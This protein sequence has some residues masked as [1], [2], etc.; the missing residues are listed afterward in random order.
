MPDD[1]FISKFITDLLPLATSSISEGDL[2]RQF[3]GMVKSGFG[4]EEAEISNSLSNVASTGTLDEYVANT[5]KAYIDN[6]L[7]EYSSFPEL[8]DYKGRGFR[9]CAILPI[10]ANGR[11][12]STLRMLSNQES[13]FTENMLKTVD[14]AATFFA[15][16]Y[17]YKSEISKNSRLAEYFDASFNSGVAQMLV[18]KDDSIVK[19]NKTAMLSFGMAESGIKNLRQLLSIGFDDLMKPAAVNGI[20]AYFS[21]SDSNNVYRITPRRV[22]DALLHV[23]MVNVTGKLILDSIM[24]SIAESRDMYVIFARRDFTIITS[25]KNFES[26]LRYPSSM[27]SGKQ[28]TELLKENDA[29]ALLDA[30]KASPGKP[31]SLQFNIMAADFPVSIR[32]AVKAE[33]FGYVIILVNTQAEKSAEEAK[34]NINEFVDATSDVVITVDNL[35]YI[36]DCNLPVDR[37][38]GYGREELVGRAIKDLYDDSSILDRDMTY[39]REKGKVDN[40]YV[41]LVKKDMTKEAAVQSMRLIRGIG[42]EDR[43]LL[44]IKELET[45]RRMDD[46]EMAIRRNNNEMVKLKS[47][48]DLKSQFIYNISHELK[49]PLTNIK[50]FSTLLGEGQ[51]GELNAEQK[52][53]VSTIVSESDRLLQII[54]QVLDAAKLEPDQVKMDFKEVDMHALRDNPSIRALEDAAR[55]KGLEFEWNVYGSVPQIDADPSRLIQVFVNLVGNSIK[56]TE[57]G[58]IKVNIKPKGRT[59]IECEVVDTGIGISDAD[60]KHL[61]KKFY[62]ATQSKTLVKQYG[63]GTGLGLVIAK[64]IIRHHGGKIDVES[65][66]G[67]GSRFFF[68]LNIKRPKKQGARAASQ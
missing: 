63:S 6:Q 57:K 54:Q 33:I 44:I 10:V 61:F 56:F 40:S 58:S 62:Q 68:T 27:L 51:A 11:V 21:T 32:A 31:V 14:I 25:S 59:K 1:L 64:D 41:S 35:G 48:S 38:L 20:D 53:Y 8:I 3:L 60:R 18:S 50:G 2:S 12:I 55:N 66:P 34:E 47:E 67:K 28:F 15:F 19:A 26:L 23:S 4:I 7:S 9:S 36:T 29:R 52:D 49:T 43:Y 45:K 17:M 22:S 13:K 42:E 30:V 65:E 39:V 37:V 46:Q 16:S 24:D 5:R